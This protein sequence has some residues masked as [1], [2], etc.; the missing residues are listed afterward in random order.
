MVETGAG[1]TPEMT[2]LRSLQIARKPR[3]TFQIKN[4]WF[5]ESEFG[6]GGTHQCPFPAWQHG[7]CQRHHPERRRKT[8]ARRVELLEAKLAKAKRELAGL[9]AIETFKDADLVNL[10]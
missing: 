7:L 10:S 3:C 5:H 1:P 2:F 9:P 8:L 6:K 4:Q